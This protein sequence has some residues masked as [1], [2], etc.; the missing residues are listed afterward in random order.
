M[1]Q[2]IN[3]ISS[4]L[5][6]TIIA[7]FYILLAFSACRSSNNS[8]AQFK[9]GHFRY[10]IK[11]PEY[12]ADYEID[13]S[14]S[15]QVETDVNSGNYSKLSIKWT[16]PCTYELKLIESTLKFSDTIQQLR[17]THS[18]KTEIL[19]WTK[20]YYVFRSKMDKVDFVLTDTLWIEK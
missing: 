12:Q 20:D 7:F 4:R 1:I 15:V 2:I 5:A 18:L 17:K 3:N 16:S 14:D 8:C 13:R 6:L 19:S 10:H 11:G 9:T